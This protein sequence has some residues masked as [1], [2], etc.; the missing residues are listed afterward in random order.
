MTV[1]TLPEA[2]RASNE[3]VLTGRVTRAPEERA[4]PSGD[5]LV[6][7]RISVPREGKRRG[8]RQTTDWFDCTVWGARVRR[9]VLAWS[10]GDRVCV[11]GA[12]RRRPFRG[13]EGFQTRVDVEVLAARR[14]ET[15]AQR[16][17]EQRDREQS[18]RASSR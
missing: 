5:V 17:R 16:D 11:T 7:F 9:S 1:H 4:L 12:L 2:G 10:V 6:H 18:E 13:G 3:V 14:L 8:S 15:A